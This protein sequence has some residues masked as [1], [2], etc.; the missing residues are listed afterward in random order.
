METRTFVWGVGDRIKAGTF[1]L[2]QKQFLPR[3]MQGII[4][5]NVINRQT[6]ALIPM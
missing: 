2:R 3:G 4:D 1:E 6:P 5:A